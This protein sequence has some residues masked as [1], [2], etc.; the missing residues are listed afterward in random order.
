L[1]KRKD[2]GTG[3]ARRI[4]YFPVANA[5]IYTRPEKRPEVPVSGFGPKAVDLAARIGDG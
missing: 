4:G 1:R 5:R 3:P 2:S